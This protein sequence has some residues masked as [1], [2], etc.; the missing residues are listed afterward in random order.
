MV[1][2]VQFAVGHIVA[3][4]ACCGYIGSAHRHRHRV[5]LGPMN[6]ELASIQWQEVGWR[7]CVVAISTFGRREFEEVGDSAAADA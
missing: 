7:G 2:V 6:Y 4:G 5:V 3:C 1:D